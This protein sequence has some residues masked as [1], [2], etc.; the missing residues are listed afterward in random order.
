MSDKWVETTL[1]EH[2]S[3]RRGVSYKSSELVDTWI[4]G[5]EPLLNLKSVERGG[6][7]RP[8]GLKFFVGEAKESQRCKAGDLI[9]ACTDLTR[10]RDIVGAP[11]VVPAE[12][13]RGVFSLDLVRLE[14]KTDAVLLRFMDLVLQAPSARSFMQTHSSG[15]T[16]IHLKTK[17]VPDFTFSLPPLP[18]QRRIVDLLAHLDAHIANLRTEVD[19][20]G[21][22]QRIQLRV[23]LEGEGERVRLGDLAVFEYGKALKAS[24][25]VPGGTAVFGS[26]GMTGSHTD[27]LRSDSGPVVGRKGVNS[28]PSPS[29]YIRRDNEVD[30]RSDYSGW[31]GAGAVRWAEGPHWVIDTAYVANPK[32]DRVDAKTLFWLLTALDLPQYATLT[33]LPGLSRES[34]YGLDVQLSHNLAETVQTLE[35]S[36]QALARLLN[37]VTALRE[38]RQRLLESLLNRE[39]VLDARYDNLLQGVGS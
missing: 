7:Y 13:A 2:F 34:V 8:D 38:L 30:R 19:C 18:V 23:L 32:S 28:L 12:P 15:T 6:G 9:L 16:V 11:F 24:E 1:G 25:R 37:E 31:G 22:L 36:S 39:S 3:V 21:V 29:A 20:L 17:E 10:A 14:P 4:S 26:A 5:S 27:A 35:A 33:T